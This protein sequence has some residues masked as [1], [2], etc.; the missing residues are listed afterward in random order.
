MNTT[1]LATI[2]VELETN[3][4]VKLGLALAIP[5]TI[6]VALLVLTKKYR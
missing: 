3:N 5:L 6:Y 1:N 2:T 4:F